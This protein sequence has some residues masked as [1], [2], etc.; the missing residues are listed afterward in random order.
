[1]TVE[2]VKAPPAPADHQSIRYGQPVLAL[3]RE[4]NVAHIV[5]VDAMNAE[6]PVSSS[7]GNL[8][9]ARKSYTDCP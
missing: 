8:V 4:D 5:F 3:N 9:W 6:D 7:T 1:M 2:R